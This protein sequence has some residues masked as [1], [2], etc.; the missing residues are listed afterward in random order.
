MAQKVEVTLIDD[1]DG[2]K[3]DEVISFGLGGKNYEIDLSSKN[4]KKLRDA[5]EPYVAAA[6]KV[7]FS[8]KTT[9]R[10]SSRQAASDALDT[11]AIR[12]WAKA[13]GLPISDRGRISADVVEKYKAAQ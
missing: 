9:G 8:Q 10:G 2:G 6:R 7:T 12:E 13:A 4:A 11:A 1:L 3:A 5:L